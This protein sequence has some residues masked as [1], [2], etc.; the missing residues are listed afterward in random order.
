MS[1]HEETEM[2]Q[3]KE[4]EMAG[5]EETILVTGSFRLPASEAE[6][7][8]VLLSGI[9]KVSLAHPG[10]RQYRFAFDLDDPTEI[11]LFEEWDDVESIHEHLRSPDMA[12][13]AELGEHLVQEDPIV[14]YRS[15]DSSP[16][17]PAPAEGDPAG[18]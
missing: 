4:T 17:V 16:F 2:D 15:I 10:C 11:F 6:R 13:F 8:H 5:A 14:L 1:D 7:L 12:P 9:R 18:G 3:E